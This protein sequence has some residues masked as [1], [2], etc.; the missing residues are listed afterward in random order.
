MFFISPFQPALPPTTRRL[1]QFGDGLCQ[2]LGNGRRHFSLG[3]VV[4]QKFF[5]RGKF[6]GGRLGRRVLRELFLFLRAV[7]G[8]VFHTASGGFGKLKG[9][10]F[11]GAMQFAAHGVGGLFG[12]GGHFVITEFFIGDE[13]QEQAIFLGQIRERFLDAFA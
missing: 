5:R 9:E 1:R 7:F 11:P 4:P 10:G 6:A 3:G 8:F 2:A 13:Q 12:Q